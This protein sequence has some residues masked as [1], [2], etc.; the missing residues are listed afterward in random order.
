MKNADVYRPPSHLVILYALLFLTKNCLCLTLIVIMNSTY[1]KQ[2]YTCMTE[3]NNQDSKQSFK[4]TRINITTSLK[5]TLKEICIK[6]ESQYK[7]CGRKIA[8][9]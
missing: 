3:D 6:G 9:P 8:C 5:L 2:M 7:N 4:K 1:P